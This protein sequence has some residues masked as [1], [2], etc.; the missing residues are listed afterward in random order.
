MRMLTEGKVH[1]EHKT[2]HVSSV[3]AR[4]GSVLGRGE[5]SI[6]RKESPGK[7]QR[8]ESVED[9]GRTSVLGHPSPGSK[10]NLWAPAQP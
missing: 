8:K 1:Q 4:R 5:N 2:V 7:A 6:Y 10:D 3:V 9:P